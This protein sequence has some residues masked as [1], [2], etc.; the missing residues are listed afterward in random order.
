MLYNAKPFIKIIKNVII[1]IKKDT[2]LKNANNLKNKII[3]NL[4]RKDKDK[5]MLYRK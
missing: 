1:I 5:L 3:K 4:S 2:L